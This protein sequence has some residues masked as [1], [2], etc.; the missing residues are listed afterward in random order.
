V[1]DY[2]VK[3]GQGCHIFLDVGSCEELLEAILKWWSDI[4]QKDKLIHAISVNIND[5]GE[6]EATVYWSYLSPEMK[7]KVEREVTALRPI[8]PV[9]P[10][11]I[12]GN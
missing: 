11:N 6:I 8:P 4:P 1:K 12:S 10:E 3:D 5:D 7:Q 2:E 9:K